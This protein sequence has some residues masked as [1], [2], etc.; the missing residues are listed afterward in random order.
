MHRDSFCFHSFSFHDHC[1]D[2]R[3]NSFVCKMQFVKTLLFMC[4]KMLFDLIKIIAFICVHKRLTS[5]SISMN[6]ETH[7]LTLYKEVLL[8]SLDAST[9]NYLWYVPTIVLI[10]SRF[11]YIVE[12]IYASHLS[13]IF[14]TY[15]I[16]IEAE[17]LQSK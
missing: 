13:V 16:C 2:A 5:L 10:T 6:Y 12:K 15:H 3:C 8:I 4:C 1:L 9:L 17:L 7:S 14:R 11:L